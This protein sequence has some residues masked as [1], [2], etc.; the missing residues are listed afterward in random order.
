M[1]GGGTGLADE[2][3]LQTGGSANDV[4]VAA[5]EA[6]AV[7]A[8][9]VGFALMT[10]A[11]ASDTMFA[12]LDGGGLL[13]GLEGAILTGLGVGGLLRPAT[14]ARLLRPPGR[15]VILAA[16]FAVAGAF[17]WGIQ[18]HFS[19]VA[20]A[21]VWIAVIV[22][23]PPWIVTC[24]LVSAAGYLVDLL[25]KGHSLAWTLTPAGREL[26]VNQWV[27]LVANA[28]VVLVLVVLLRR[29]V[30]GVP[31]SLATARAGGPAVTTA[32]AAAVSSEPVALLPRADAA[33]VI[34]PLTE[35]ECKVLGLLRD[36]L[37]PKQ[38][39]LDLSVTLATVRS[40]IAAAKRKTG[41]RTIEQLVGI[42][43]QATDGN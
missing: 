2:T 17:D 1:S 10:I 43:A 34:A 8:L 31:A 35:A 37:V 33:S 15:V 28:G 40:H 36:G 16:L 27:D 30:A 12:L 41:A 14:A 29:F 11:A 26:V 32:L 4:A 23:S 22:S 19:E 25:L 13:A 7:A 21:I 39:A 38:A 42:Y 18:R 24:V 5:G 3:A 6:L 20:P 9:R